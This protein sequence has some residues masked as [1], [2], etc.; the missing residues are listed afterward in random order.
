MDLFKELSDSEKSLLV[1]SLVEEQFKEG[2]SIISQGEE[3]SHTQRTG[4]SA[5]SVHG[6]PLRL[7][8]TARAPGEEGEAFYIVKSGAVQ[9]LQT[10]SEGVT[11]VIKDKLGP[12][13]YFGEMA[14]LKNEVRQA[15]I[16]ATAPTTCM[17]LDRGTFQRLLGSNIGMEILERE[18]KRREAELARNNRPAIHMEDLKQLAIL[19]VGTFGRVKLVLHAKDNDRPYALKCMRKGQVIALKQVEHVMNEKN[20]L[21]QCDH[22]FLLRLAATYQDENEIYMLLELALGGELFSVLR[23]R[24]RFEEPQARFYAGCVQSAFAYLHDKSIVYRDLKPEN[25]LFDAQGYLKVSEPP[26]SQLCTRRQHSRLPPHARCPRAACS[27]PAGRRLRLRQ[28][29]RGPHV[30]ALRHARVP[31]A[32]DHHEQG[33]QPRRRLVGPSASSTLT[34]TPLPVPLTPTPHPVPDADPSPCP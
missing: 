30:D 29:Y 8:H 5:R 24:N 27:P 7:L 2:D 25:L 3:P 6:A 14:L 4:P 15:S 32:R 11:A 31:R 34:P 19:G 18:A 33:A 13:E 22:P 10:N 23:E 9:V 26:L 12:S 16:S 1:D 20:L 28:V 17:K 21:E